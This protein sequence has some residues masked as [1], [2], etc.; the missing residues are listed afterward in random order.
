MVLDITDRKQAERR[1]KLLLNELNHRVKN[2]LATVQSIAA[3]TARSCPTVEEFKTR[4]EPRLLA[5][6]KA[7]DRLTRNR[8]E[9]AN[10][11]DIVEEELAAHGT[12]GRHFNASGP[13]VLLPPRASLSL[14]MALHELAT[15]AVKYGS[16]SVPGGRVDV[17]WG[18]QCQESPLST[19]VEISWAES[20][21]P[22]ASAPEMTGFGSR[23][24]KVTAQ[25]LQGTSIS[26]FEPDGLQWSL[27]FPLPVLADGSE[28]DSPDI[29]A[30]AR[31]C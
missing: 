7:H 19:I 16:L 20:C 6:S 3:Q 13:D 22:L 29:A 25:E 23:L 24:L 28:H 11:R 15:N 5:L 1:Q 18:T 31:D 17:T 21:G 12:A 10:L 2:T 8:W 30:P 4:F 14:S 9:G 26:R 27:R